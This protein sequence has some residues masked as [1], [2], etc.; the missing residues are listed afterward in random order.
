[1]ARLHLPKQNE[2]KVLFN[3]LRDYT[4]TDGSSWLFVGDIGLRRFIAQEVDRLDDIISY[5]VE[6]NPITFLHPLH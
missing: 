4:Q 6:I 5:E 2:I 3:A 1:M